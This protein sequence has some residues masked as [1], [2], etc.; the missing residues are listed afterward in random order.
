MPRPLPERLAV[1]PENNGCQTPQD[2]QTHV[3][4]D[5]RDIS[6]LDDPWSYELREA[7]APDVFVDCNRDEDGAG[8]RLVGVDGVG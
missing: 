5:R 7:V 4:H 8:D 6:A 3:R 2:D 1:I